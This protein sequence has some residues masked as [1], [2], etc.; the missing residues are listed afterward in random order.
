MNSLQKSRY[1]MFEMSFPRVTMSGN[2]SSFI[3][4]GFPIWAWT[5]ATDRA[6]LDYA[7]AL[8]LTRLCRVPPEMSSLLAMRVRLL[9]LLPV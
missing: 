5:T 6:L 3:P 4:G 7:A 2:S 9:T 8:K 1:W